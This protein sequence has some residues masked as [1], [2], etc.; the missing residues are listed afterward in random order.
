[1]RPWG[2]LSA[3]RWKG[4]CDTPPGSAREPGGQLS[5]GPS[6]HPAAPGRSGASIF[7]E[8]PARDFLGTDRQEFAYVDSLVGPVLAQTLDDNPLAFAVGE[9]EGDIVNCESD[10][11][12]LGS[13]SV[14]SY[15]PYSMRAIH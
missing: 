3:A 5:A 9:T 15:S 11:G 7:F 4:V 10:L 8:H 1:M 6:P 12:K 13:L 14:S 2:L